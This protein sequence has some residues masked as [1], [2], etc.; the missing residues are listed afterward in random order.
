MADID[1]LIKLID[2][3]VVN[4]V[5]GIPVAQKQLYNELIVLIKEL[6]IDNGKLRN[7][8]SNIKLLGR[9]KTKINEVIVNDKYKKQVAQYLDQFNA[10]TT[11]QNSYFTSL[12]KKYSP[13]KLLEA[14]K[15]GINPIVGS[16]KRRYCNK[17]NND[18]MIKR[19]KT[20]YPYYYIEY[21]KNRAQQF[22]KEHYG[23][24]Y[25]GGHHFENILTRFTMSYWLYEKFG[26]DKRKI[27]LSAQ[28]MSGEISREKAIAE[29]NSLPY[30]RDEKDEP[31]KDNEMVKEKG[32]TYGSK[33]IQKGWQYFEF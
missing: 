9:L 4:F 3:A 19:I 31:Y 11:W 27:T 28:V 33:N 14:I 16:I 24:E 30:N 22:L 23:W 25:Y 15:L 7:T 12:V 18:G 17:I 13:P 21:N 8:V 10:V 26:I 5:D 32:K 29:I 1:Q 2:D 20:L 6:E